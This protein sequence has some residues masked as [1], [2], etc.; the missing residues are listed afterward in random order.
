MGEKG[1]LQLPPAE[2]DED[3]EDL[4]KRIEALPD[5]RRRRDTI[6]RLSQMFREEL[7]PET[8]GE[9]I[10]NQAVSSGQQQVTNV[11][12]QPNVTV[13]NSSD[14]RLPK[15]SGSEK[16]GQG[17][18][19]YRKWQREAERLLKD[20]SSTEAQKKKAVLKSLTGKADDIA[21]LNQNKSVREL[22]ELF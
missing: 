17:E 14:R 12:C 8:P 6:H 11:T 18:V 10:T 22:I 5:P 16:L 1:E 21:D 2:V 13:D 4:R 9:K 7:P 15:F 19:T 20:S 3:F